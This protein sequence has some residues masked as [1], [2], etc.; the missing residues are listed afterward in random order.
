MSG[1]DASGAK[2]QQPETVPITIIGGYLGAGK[3][4]LINRMLAQPTLPAGTAI[5]V[6]DFGD[7]NIDAELIKSASPDGQVIDPLATLE[8]G[9]LQQAIE[10]TLSRCCRRRSRSSKTAR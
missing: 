1:K 10:A 4:T 7:I 2:L 8:P 6:N 9:A 3:T 5:L